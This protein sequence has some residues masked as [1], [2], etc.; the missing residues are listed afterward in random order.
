MSLYKAGFLLSS[1]EGPR[2]KRNPWSL[3][4]G[5]PAG[6]PSGEWGTA[7]GQEGWSLQDAPPPRYKRYMR[8]ARTERRENTSS[9]QS[10]SPRG[11]GPSGE[12]VERAPR[13]AGEALSAPAS[14][15]LLPADLGFLHGPQ[16]GVIDD[17]LLPVPAPRQ[18]G[19]LLQDGGVLL[20]GSRIIL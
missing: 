16:V 15:S 2:K 8:E 14:N 4:G 1:R 5:G 6:S 17:A 18:G 9:H 20:L 19:V 7:A 12:G 10:S 13:V 3:P 11:F